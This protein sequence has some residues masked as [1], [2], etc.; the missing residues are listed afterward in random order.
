MMSMKSMILTTAVL[1]RAMCALLNARLQLLQAR[2]HVLRATVDAARA[3]V[4]LKVV[5]TLMAKERAL[6]KAVG[7]LALASAATWGR[8]QGRLEARIAALEAA[9]HV[10][11]SRVRQG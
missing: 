4:T 11:E 3:R 7:K 9:V 2:L 10:A 8:M 1:R 5:T 6:T